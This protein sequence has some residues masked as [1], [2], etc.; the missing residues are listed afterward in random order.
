[1]DLN[2]IK[3]KLSNLQ[4]TNGQKSHL[5]KPSPGKQQIRII[6]Y[7]FDKEFPFIELWFHYG[8]NGKTILS[9][10][11]FNEKDPIEEFSTQ[12][13]NS[14]SKDDYQLSRKLSPKL[15]V[16]APIIVRGEETDGVRYWGFGKM[17]YQELLSIMSDE[18][19]GD[20]TDTK[21]GRD[22]VVDFKTAEETGKSFPST[23]IRVKPNTT[24]LSENDEV[25]KRWLDEQK[26]IKELFKHHTYDE[27]KELLNNWL[28]GVPSE[29]D[30]ETESVS[31]K[32]EKSVEESFD[33]LFTT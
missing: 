29:S 13:R 26:S 24:T 4:N 22:V 30:E 16:Y 10:K 11:S 9:P 6:P 28:D 5:W 14:G 1:M 15:R 19:Y 31:N 25:I 12:L 23:T 18:D 27:M 20:I 7:K 8:I 17:V 2:R 32:E 3:N 33:E 21:I